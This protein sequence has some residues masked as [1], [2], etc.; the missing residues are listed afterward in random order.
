MGLVDRLQAAIGDRYRV[1]REIGAGGMAT[2]YL[3]QDLKHR[4]PVAVKVMNPQVAAAM[5]AERFLREIRLVAGIQHPHVL[6]L[7]DSGE[8]DGLFYYI[9]PFVKGESLRSRLG[10]GAALVAPAAVVAPPAATIVVLPFENASP[11]PNDAYF[12]IALTDEVISDLSKV[13]AIRVISRA[14]SMQLRGTTKDLRTIAR[15]FNVRYAL[16]GSVRRAGDTLRIVVE[17]TDTASDT[18]IWSDKYTGHVANVFEL[19]ERLS[20]QIAAALKVS[21]TPEESQRLIARPGDDSREKRSIAIRSLHSIG[22]CAPARF[23]G[24][25]TG[26]AR[27]K[28]LA[29]S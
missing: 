19:Q 1:E 27:L 15:E 26:H 21:V 25:A 29:S 28:W 22:G 9:M 10:R 17:L 24:S 7:H 16:T 20:R 8:A 18:P 14:S 2:V 12:S 5:N 3:A 4:R 11:D 13:K 6:P 23:C